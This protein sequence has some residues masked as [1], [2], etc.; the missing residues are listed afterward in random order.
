M[1]SLEQYQPVP[2]PLKETF[3]QRQ[4][5]Q[6]VLSNYLRDRLRINVSQSLVAQY[7]NGYVQIPEH[8]EVELESLARE[9][10][11]QEARL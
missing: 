10:E 6:I 4:I 11:S 3:R 9:L 5:S 8:I 2:H 7:L 1:I